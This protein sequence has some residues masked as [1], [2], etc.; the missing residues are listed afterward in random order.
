MTSPDA[1]ERLEVI[2]SAV[3]RA[4]ALIVSAGAGSLGDPARIL[5]DACTDLAAIPASQAAQSPAETRRLAESIARAAALLGHAAEFYQSW[6]RIRGAMC[7]GYRPDGDPGDANLPA[8][9]CL[10]G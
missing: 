8:R 1:G 2:G 10:R 4:C 3:D 9:L 7:S 6:R 5:E